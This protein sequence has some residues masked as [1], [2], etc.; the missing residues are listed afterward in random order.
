LLAFCALPPALAESG[1]AE[2]VQEI[3]RRAEDKQSEGGICTKAYGPNWP[4]V[5]P[6][7]ASLRIAPKSQ[8]ASWRRVAQNGRVT[9]GIVHVYAL[10]EKGGRV[11]RRLGIRS[12]QSGSLCQLSGVNICSDGLGGWTYDR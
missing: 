2:L 3:I 10:Y 12:C 7:S 8:V 6:E 5:A 4:I 11:C 1:G 9:C